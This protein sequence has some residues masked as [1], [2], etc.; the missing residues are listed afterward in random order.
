M[1]R[2]TMFSKVK[3]KRGNTCAQVFATAEG[4]TRAYPMQ[5]KLQAQKALWLLLQWEGVPNTMVMDGLKEQVLGLF[6]HQCREAG[7][8]VKQTEPHTPWS[9]AAK[10]A[11]QELK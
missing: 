10:G 6:C 5:K 2:D 4:W 3:S 7:S 9:N 8:H 11:I 1:Y